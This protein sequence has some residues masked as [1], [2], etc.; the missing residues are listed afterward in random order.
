MRT[1]WQSSR[2]SY[3]ALPQTYQRQD[4]HPAAK[5]S[6]KNLSLRNFPLQAANFPM[7]SSRAKGKSVTLYLR[8]NTSIQKILRETFCSTTLTLRFIREKKLPL[9]EWST[10][11]SH[12]SLTSSPVRLN[13]RVRRLTGARPQS[14]HT[15][16]VTTASIS[17]TT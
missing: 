9:S 17:A 14:I 8:Q 15:W 1:R 16:V 6:L 4:R 5:R 13:V 12:L 11:P 10:I 3:S 2:H 7:Y